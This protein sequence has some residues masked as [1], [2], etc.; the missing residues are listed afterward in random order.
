M[1]LLSSRPVI[2]AE[3]GSRTTSRLPC[4]H[5]L[6]RGRTVVRV[7]PGES[8]K[9]PPEERKSADERKAAERRAVQSEPLKSNAPE[10]TPVPDSK[11]ELPPVI[12]R[13]EIVAFALVSLLVISVVAV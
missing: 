9:P 13:A 11:G 7:L 1:E 2:G 3:F 6:A 12:R 4:H 10:G 5:R 8:T